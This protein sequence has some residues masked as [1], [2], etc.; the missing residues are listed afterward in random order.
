MKFII[1][2]DRILSDSGFRTLSISPNEENGYRPYE[3]FISSLI[4]CSGTL[5]RNILTKKRFAYER[6]GMEAAATRNAAH[7][8]RI[9]SISITAYISADKGLTEI[10]T[11][12]IVNLVI[13]NCGMIQS[14]IPAIDVKL[15]IKYSLPSGG[16]D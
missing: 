8:N 5:L 10:Q 11:E 7:A 14:V 1:E 2:Q 15:S 6:I 16:S 12:K 13:Q 4:G 9:E 3:L